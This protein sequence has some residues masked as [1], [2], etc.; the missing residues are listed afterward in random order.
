MTRRWT[1]VLALAVVPFASACTM[2]PDYTR[3]PVTSPEQ[4]RA[5]SAASESI[6]NVPWWEL[7][8]DEQLRTL[9]K[10]ALEQNRDLRIAIERIEETRALYGISRSQLWPQVDARASAGGVGFSD[11][12][13]TH[14]PDADESAAT[15]DTAL[16]NVDVVFSWEL[17]FFGRVRRA[18]EAQLALLLE[19]K[20]AHRS[21]TVTLVA[22]VARAYVELRDLD[23]RLEISRRTLDSRGEYVVL[24]RQ[25]FDGGI[26]PEVDW[27]QAEAE[28]YRVQAFVVD[29]ERLVAQKEN[30]ISV[31]VGAN[32]GAVVRGR[33]LDQQPIPPQV[34]AGL[35]AMLLEQRP[36]VRAAEQRLVSATARIGEAIAMRYPRISLTGSYGFASTDLEDL[37]DGS[38]QSWNIFASLLQPIFNA[39]RNQRRVEVRESQQRQAVYAYENTLLQALREVE[40]ALVAVR[41]AGEKRAAQSAR[42][43]AERLV[44][45][46]SEARYRGGVAAYLEVLDAQRSLFTAEIDETAAISEHVTALIRLYKALGGGWPTVTAASPSTS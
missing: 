38:S 5:E 39:E 40:D 9:I 11:A 14:T 20:E 42:V 13:L 26:T 28:F 19:T 30:E 4:W 24:A 1:L 17:D 33:S 45:Q 7:F 21:V 31:L 46:L 22:E 36:D 25:R 29:L 18:N 32:P 12:S 27:R 10:I 8:Q 43:Q 16:F 3:P 23:R 6:A 2:G 41:K 35:P 44:L 34:P 15:G 37:L